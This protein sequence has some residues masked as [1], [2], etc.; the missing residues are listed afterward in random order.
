MN[1]IPDDLL[2]RILEY[3]EPCEVS[4]KLNVYAHSD[5]IDATLYDY[6]Q[7]ASKAQLQNIGWT[8]DNS[9]CWD[10]FLES[11]SFGFCKNTT[12][13]IEVTEQLTGVVVDNNFYVTQPFA[14]E[15]RD[16]IDID[17]IQDWEN[18]WCEGTRVTVNIGELFETPLTLKHLLP[19][20]RLSLDC[21]SSHMVYA[22]LPIR[23]L[24][25]HHIDYDV[26]M[27]LL[28]RLE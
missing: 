22:I 14:Q 11:C 4:L 26:W 3:S 15:E 5:N 18:D 16:G 6:E 17:D 10:M 9:C 21:I 7:Y 25:S 19:I 27:N 12:S 24:W 13:F 20:N 2:K 23:Q 1:T 28:I 8:A